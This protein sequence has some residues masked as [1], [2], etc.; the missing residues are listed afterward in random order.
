MAYQGKLINGLIAEY[1]SE[2]ATFHCEYGDGR[3]N[4]LMA[5]LRYISLKY[6]EV[7][8]NKIS[9]IES[10]TFDLDF[11]SRFEY[12]G[13][14]AIF[15]AN[16]SYSEIKNG[17]TIPAFCPKDKGWISLNGEDEENPCLITNY[18]IGAVRS[19]QCAVK[20]YVHKETHTVIVFSNLI[21]PSM[22]DAFTSILPKILLWIYPEDLNTLDD[23]EKSLF[24]AISKEDIATAT[25]ILDGFVDRLNIGEEIVKTRLHG[26]N[27]KFVDDQIG[28]ITTSI[29]E[30]YNSIDR[31]E[32]EIAGF[33]KS[34]NEKN[35]RLKGLYASK[36]T[37]TDEVADFFLSHKQLEITDIGEQ[38]IGFYI[39]DTLEWYDHDELEAMFANSGSYIHDFSKK[40][41]ALLRGLFVENKA[42]IRVRSYFILQNTS[43]LFSRS[44]QRFDTLAN[45]SDA[46]P[47]PHLGHHNCL[48]A[49]ENY[50]DKALQNGDWD[51]A[52]EQAI[53]ATKNINFGDITVIT[54]F[55]ADLVKYENTK[56][57]ICDDGTEMT[58]KQFFNKYCKE[59]AV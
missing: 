46:L 17:S 24:A 50:I 12:K 54:E 43:V 40:K 32:Q 1:L 34:V 45:M 41:K 38:T 59:Y 3:S 39:C 11:I 27:N 44:R 28:S 14:G 47:H 10:S 18:I 2:N 16:A 8:N 56:C 22:I 25:S 58:I 52:I 20:I 30:D 31:R 23:E 7:P 13:D 53:S 48:G 35:L 51:I 4:L 21:T 49:N 55:V 33:L 29:K 37:P 57:I 26:W 36:M 42:K 9:L 19:G 6:K 5:V 15:I